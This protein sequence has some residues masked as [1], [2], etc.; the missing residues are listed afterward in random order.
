M[1]KTQKSAWYFFL[2]SVG[3]IL[4]QIC[5]IK[6]MYDI[7]FGASINRCRNVLAVS[8][9]LLFF[10][11]FMVVSALVI[12][13]SK[14]SP[15][16]IESDERDDLIKKRALLV[17]FVSVWILLAASYLVL[18]ITLGLNASVPVYVLPL[19]CME[20][21]VFVLIV[22]NLAVLVQYYIGGK[23]GEG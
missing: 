1:N 13:R 23:D 12:Y 6:P 11:G 20:I 4:F 3:V 5:C 2:T 19:F 16:E 15:T 8:V 18:W 21:G 10:L 22:F 14:Q 7:F 17:S 9:L